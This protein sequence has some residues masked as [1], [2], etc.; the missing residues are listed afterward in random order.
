MLIVADGVIKAM[1]SSGMHFSPATTMISTWVVDLRYLFEQGVFASTLFFVGA[2]FLET[3][4]ILTVGF[5]RLDSDRMAVKGPDD[6][7]IV[8]IGRR[9]GTKSEAES[10]AT[11]LAERL[12]EGGNA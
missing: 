12:R 3:R 11:V 4:S 1:L 2:K 7:N 9:Y 10:V 5:D 8:W 6:D